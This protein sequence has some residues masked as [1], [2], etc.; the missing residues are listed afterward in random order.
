MAPDV[1]DDDFVGA[2]GQEDSDSEASWL[3]AEMRSRV[4]MSEKLEQLTDLFQG[5]GSS[6]SGR[7]GAKSP[8]AVL[9]VTRPERQSDL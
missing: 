6:H 8:S 3:D 5:V 1:L 7:A 2:E 9:G 4:D